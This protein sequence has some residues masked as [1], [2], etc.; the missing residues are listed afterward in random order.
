MSHI[1][2]IINDLLRAKQGQPP[3]APS[4]K[5]PPIEDIPEAPTSHNKAPTLTPKELAAIQKRAYAHVLQKQYS[6]YYRQQMDEEP[7]DFFNK[8]DPL[9]S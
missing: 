5:D 2:D 8:D 7:D 6:E 3:Q 1:D 4:A 9:R